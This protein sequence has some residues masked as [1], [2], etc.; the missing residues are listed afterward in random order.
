[1]SS[2][3][4]LRFT[5]AG[6][7]VIGALAL[8]HVGYYFPRVVDD[9]FISL[10]FAESF[11]AGRG[12]VF[13]AGEHVEGYSSPLWM[14]LQ[15]IG[16]FVG[17]EG[18]TWTK[19]LGLVSFGAVLV[20]S[21]T[22]ARERLGAHPRHA[23]LAPLFLAMNS[24]LVAWS[25]LGLETP[26][27]LAL[28][29]WYPIV[30]GRHL[31]SATRRRAYAAAVV[32]IAL[33]CARPEAPLYLG[34]I[35]LAELVASPKEKLRARAISGL[36][37]ALPVLGVLAV[38]LI[39][40]RAYF[41]LWLP[42]TYYVKGASSGWELAKLT[43]LMGDGAAPFERVFYVG[44]GALAFGLAVTQRAPAPLA[45]ILCALFFTASVER[46]WMPSLR[47]LLPVSVFA[48]VAWAWGVDSL[49]RTPHLGALSRP[50][51]FLFAGVVVGG[52]WCSPARRLPGPTAASVSSTSTIGRGRFRRPATRPRT[53]GSR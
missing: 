10:R 34:A 6:A 30:L 21:Y 37:L 43:P 38:L 29:V 48:S 22:L 46:D 50:F 24:H 12:I 44:G 53:R 25:V 18:V 23:L 11:A 35:A 32:A 42:H 26:A 36:R 41:G 19:L 20:G 9:L 2:D 28:L 14:F 49:M 52:S 13:N 15:A 27:Y 51:A 31:E 3:S 47:H 1:V 33:A 16:L 4:D 8:A 40:R 5:R 45:A 7:V 39:A 17:F